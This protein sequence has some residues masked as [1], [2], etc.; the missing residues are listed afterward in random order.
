MA[1]KVGWRAQKRRHEETADWILRLQSQD[2]NLEDRQAF[3]DWLKADPKNRQSFEA[4]QSLMG[5]AEAVLHGQNDFAK[6]LT[7]GEGHL[8]LKSTLAAFM[9][10][11]AGTGI[12]YAV[13][14]P[15]RLKADVISGPD[16]TRLLTL[17][18]GSSVL[19][20]ASSAVA[21]TLTAR[22]R[23]IS[24]L[25]GEAFFTVAPDKARPFTVFAQGAKTTAVGTAFDINIGRET[26]D[27]TVTE[28]AVMIEAEKANTPIRI[29]EG[30]QVSYSPNGQISPVKPVDLNAA[31][32]WRRGE[33]VVD[34]ASLA[35]VASELGRHFSGR[36]FITSK[37]LSERRVSGRFSIVDT[38]AALA[39]LERTLGITATR[40][41]PIIILREN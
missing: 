41:G 39:F 32:A 15:L 18:D 7:S 24:L 35:F 6:D 40:L 37:D 13:D 28:H 33:L 27:V 38:N 31:L 8:P 25:K 34:G 11:I 20:N 36:I 9:V 26:A 22:E 21:Y 1:A 5:N 2:L 3:E 19:L 16:E 14:G 17:A 12:F 23:K 30:H 4:A 29:E 10:L